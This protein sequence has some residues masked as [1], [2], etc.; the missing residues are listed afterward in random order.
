ME[1]KNCDS[2]KCFQTTQLYLSIYLSIYLYIY[3]S[4]YISIYLYIYISIYISIYLSIYLYIYLSIY[5]Y[6]YISIYLSIH[7]F[8]YLSIYSSIYLFKHRN[9]SCEKSHYCQLEGFHL[10]IGITFQN[11]LSKLLAV[12]MSKIGVYIIRRCSKLIAWW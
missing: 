11:H 1:W 7:L 9:F 3:L 2:S 10:E 8:L 12:S 5:L 4:I 6:I